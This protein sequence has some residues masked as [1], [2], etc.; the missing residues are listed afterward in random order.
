M[1]DVIIKIFLKIYCVVCCAIFIVGYFYGCAS[2]LYGNFSVHQ[3]IFHLA[4]VNTLSL[5]KTVIATILVP[6]FLSIGLVL[7]AVKQPLRWLK[8]YLS[9]AKIQ[10]WTQHKAL[11]SFIT[12]TMA[13]LFGM[14]IIWFMS[15]DSL[16]QIIKQAQYTYNLI[17]N[18]AP[19]DTVID[20]NFAEPKNL[21]FELSTPR[22]LIVVFAESLERTFT[23]DKIFGQNL[24]PNLWQQN[25]SSVRGYAK[26]SETEWTFASIA[27]K[28]CGITYKQYFPPRTLSDNI[29]CIS[30][31][32]AQHGYNISYLQ[33]S[34]LQFVDTR[35]FF[36][37]HHFTDIE[38]IEDLP[39]ESADKLSSYKLESDKLFSI[40]FIGDI[41]DDAELL[42]IFRRKIEHLAQQPAPFM[43]VVTT[44]NT[45]PY[46]GYISRDCPKKYGDM[47]DAVLCSDSQLSA[48]VE[49]FKTQDFAANTTLIIMGDHPMMFNDVQKYLDKAKERKTL[50]LIWGYAAPKADIN[51]PFNQFDWAPTLLEM[52]GFK[53]NERKFGLGTS[54]LSTQKTLQETYK[55][56]LDERLLNNSKLY[57]TSVFKQPTAE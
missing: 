55:N 33:G 28:L 56:T 19:Y 32:M 21:Q 2:S 39:R 35:R 1:S 37:A 44:M 54:L 38:G 51:K 36:A 49:W 17:Y 45:H 25:G 42:R 27:A 4:A 8:H 9:A 11:L 34:S 24:L 40:K 14:A 26:L 41:L 15:A 18:P 29:T 22:N 43:A 16:S 10:Y 6:F 5:S 13:A 53:W 12:S 31:I 7:F 30:D 47:R 46:H 48:F 57:E 3:F 52:A 23:D 50:N 20:D